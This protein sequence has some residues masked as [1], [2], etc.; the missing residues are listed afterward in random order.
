MKL[1]QRCKYD[2]TLSLDAN[3]KELMYSLD[4]F[5]FGKF[6]ERYRLL[7]LDFV[8]WDVAIHMSRRISVNAHLL[9]GQGE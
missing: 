6:E 9:A 3:F 7:L 1:G 2:P 5:Y 8:Y 4:E